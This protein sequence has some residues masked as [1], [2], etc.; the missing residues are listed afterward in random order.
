MDLYLKFTDKAEANSVLYTEVP[1]EW[2]D[3]GDANRVVHN[4]TTPTS[5]RLG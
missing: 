2:D 4:P 5:T 3:E 1:T